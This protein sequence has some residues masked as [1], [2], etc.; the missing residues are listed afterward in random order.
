MNE[1]T[2]LAKAL[3][4][5]DGFVVLA[6]SETPAEIVIEVETA[7]AVVGCSECGTRAQAHER[8]PV[9]IRD[10]ACFGRPA[11]LRWIK[12][13]WRCADSDCTAATWTERAES[14]SARAPQHRRIQ[15]P[16]RRL[17]TFLRLISNGITVS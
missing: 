5:L 15:W 14:V 16:H 9:D 6:V 1:G 17:S 11:R 4:G 8:M 2:G 3:L 10:L 13:R 12:R 7:A